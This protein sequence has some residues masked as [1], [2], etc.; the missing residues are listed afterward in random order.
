VAV[1]P[2]SVESV[3]PDLITSGLVDGT[4]SAQL[5]ALEEIRSTAKWIAAAFA[6]VGG[7]LITGISLSE[8]GGET[9]SA[10]VWAVVGAAVAI[11][12]VLTVILFATRVLA[13]PFVLLA[14]FDQ[15]KPEPREIFW[16]TI[17]PAPSQRRQLGWVLWRLDKNRSLGTYRQ[18]NV[19]E[20]IKLLDEWRE[21]QVRAVRDLIEVEERRSRAE[22]EL[23]RVER[24]RDEL[25]EA[26]EVVIDVAGLEEERRV[27]AERMEAS[28]GELA[29]AEHRVKRAQNEL[30]VSER[31][32]VQLVAATQY[33]YVKQRFDTSRLWIVLAA[34][35]ASGGVLTFVLATS[36]PPAGT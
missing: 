23:T 22:M 33:E 27:A 35:I 1:A 21:E 15:V 10:Q 11:G 31:L 19:G 34:A 13:S 2:E 8:L 32:A 24:R 26:A 9:G 7:A 4:T 28:S 20:F 30:R 12:G 29:D 25:R 6:A 3:A 18:E 5:K 17:R 16:S 14:E 36:S